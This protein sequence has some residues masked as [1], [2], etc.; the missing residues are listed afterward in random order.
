MTKLSFFNKPKIK[1]RPY[2]TEEFLASGKE[3]LFS[4]QENNAEIE[5]LTGI[6]NQAIP[7][8]VKSGSVTKTKSLEKFTEK[9]HPTF[10]IILSG[11]PLSVDQVKKNYYFPLY[12]AGNFPL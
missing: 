1:R 9:Y 5:F 11:K 7:I 6:N 2:E 3:T 4:W 12:L 8:K 10:Q